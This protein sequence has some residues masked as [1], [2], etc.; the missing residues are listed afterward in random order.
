MNPTEASIFTGLRRVV[1]SGKVQ[2][3]AY[4]LGAAWFAIK[5]GI[6]DLTPDQ[7][8]KVW[9]TFI[10]AVGVIVRE[11][12]NAWGVEDAAKAAAPAVAPTPVNMQVNNGPAAE[13]TQNS[14]AP[15]AATS[16]PVAGDPAW[17]QPTG[18]P[19][20]PPAPPVKVGGVNL[21]P[22]GQ[23]PAPPAAPPAPY[24]RTILPGG[25]Q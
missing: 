8:S 13:N 25:K 24:S 6:T 5:F 19:Q 10:A 16:S 22:T 9:M 4:A 18:A 7:K 3:S 11:I 21:K 12:I 2:V 17:P 1:N 14:A 23:R 20:I 15:G